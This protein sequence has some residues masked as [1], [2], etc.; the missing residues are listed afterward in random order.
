M[1]D[2]QIILIGLIGIVF[3]SL[4]VY[5]FYDTVCFMGRS[6]IAMATV[7]DFQV[8]KE[9]NYFPIFQFKDE[10][11]STVTTKSPSGGKPPPYDI[12][13][14]ISILYDPLNPTNVKVNSI[15]YTWLPPLFSIFMGALVV[16]LAIGFWRRYH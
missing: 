12:G 7:I 16:V 14:R 3:F 6:R 8:N 13:D 15:I 5:L 2:R 11:G 10:S 1:K 9:G 4:G